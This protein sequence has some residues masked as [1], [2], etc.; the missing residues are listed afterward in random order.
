MRIK[1]VVFDLDGTL[2]DT[3]ADLTDAVNV[4]LHQFGY[5]HRPASEVRLWIGNGLPILCRLA[6]TAGNQSALQPPEETH[7]QQMAAAVTAHYREHRLD[8]T[9]P[10]PGIPAVLDALT[11]VR[12]SM[13]VLSN[14]P[15]LHTAPMVEA[16]FG[17]WPWIAIEGCRD[18]GQRK[19]EPQTAR[20]IVARMRLE[21]GQVLMVGDSAVD[22]QTGLNAGMVTVGVTWGF[23]DRAEL[24]DAGAHHVIDRP[25]DLLALI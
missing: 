15:H 9:K 2:A 5:P 21:T 11:D 12:V 23:R 22:V 14:K 13:A 25:A 19:P 7:I 18:D 17:E 24:I 16:L 3:L 4:G 8:K 20:T 6:I 10:Y 1:G